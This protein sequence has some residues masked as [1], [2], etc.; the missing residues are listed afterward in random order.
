MTLEKSSVPKINPRSISFFQSKRFWKKL[1]LDNVFPQ[2]ETLSS[3]ETVAYRYLK[4]VGD[5]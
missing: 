5:S 4:S 3:A 2:F 1:S